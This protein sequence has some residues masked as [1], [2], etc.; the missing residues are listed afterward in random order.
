GGTTQ[1]SSIWQS[2]SPVV[3]QVYTVSY[4]YLPGANSSPQIVRAGGS[5]FLSQ[6]DGVI[7][8]IFVDGT[9]VYQQ[10]VFGKTVNYAFTVS[11][12]L[13]SKID[14]VLDAGNN[15][16]DYGDVASFTARVDTARP[17][18]TTVA[19]SAADWSTDGIQ[20]SKNWFYGYYNK[21][22]D[23]D[24][25]FQASNFVAFPRSIGPQS[26]ANFWDQEEWRWFNGDPPLDRLGQYWMTP[27]GT[28]SGAEHWV[29]RRWVSE[30]TG[31]LTILWQALKEFPDQNNSGGGGATLRLFHNGVQRD[32]QTIA[33][34]DVHGGTRALNIPNVQ[35]GDTIDIALDPTNVDGRE[36]DDTD[37]TFV[38]VTIGGY[39]SLTSQIASS[40]DASM[41]DINA[42]A[43]IRIPF[44]TANPS[45]FNSL[46]LRMKYDDG[47]IAYLNGVEVARAN[48]PIVATWNSSATAERSDAENN[49]WQEFN[50]GTELGLL[51]GGTNILSFQGLNVSPSDPDFLILPELTASTES[52]DLAATRYFKTP[53]PGTANGI[54]ET[55]LGPLILSAVHFP[56]IPKDNDNL[57][58][59]AQVA[60][61]LRA[62]GSVRLIYRVMYGNEVNAPMFDD[63][64]HGDGAAGDG[65][66]GATIPASASSPGQMVR[67]YIFATDSAGS[68]SRFPAYD[69]PQNSPQ[70]QGTV[71][72][73]PNLTN[74]L[75]VMQWFVQNPTLAS[76][77]AGTRCSI[78][79]DGEFFDNIGV[80]GHGQ[81]SW[82]LPTYL[83]P[84][85]SMDFNL[86]SGFKLRPKSGMD[87]VKAF[88]LLSPYGDKAYMRLTLA[89]ETFRDA[90]VPTHF[91]FPIRVQ[92][93][94]AFHSVMWLVEQANDDF[95]KRNNQDDN[96]AMYKIYFP[97]TDPYTG[98]KKVN[99]VNEP[100]DD[101]AGLINGLNKTGTD[102]RQYLFD[103]VDVAE[104]VNFFATI[105]LVQ[106]EDCCYYKNY[107]L[108]RD[109]LGNGQ[110]Q[111][112]PW[113]LDLTF[114]RTFTA[115][116]S[117]FN[118]QSGGYFDTNIF[119]LDAYFDEQRASEGF[120]G[121]GQPIFEA[122]WAFPDTREM[123][124]RRWTSVQEQFLRKTNT[125]PLAFYY[126][127]RIDQLTAQ[128][129]PDAALD[130]AKWG[131][132]PY[133][134]PVV[135]SQP[136]AAAVIKT[137][138]LAPRRNWIFNTLA[139]ANGGP[140]LGTQPANAT[141][142]FGQIEWSPSSG[143]QAQE[144]IQ[145]RNTNTYP[146]D[147]SGWKLSGGIDFTFKGGTVLPTNSVL[148]VSPDVN[149]FRART[150][151]PRG[152]QGLFVQG[153]YKGQLSARG[154][155]LQLSDNTGRI[156]QSTNFTGAPSLA[157]QSLRIT[158]I[159]YHPAGFPPGLA[160]NADEFEFIELKNVGSVAIP[161][162]GVRFVNG[163]DFDLTAASL[164]FLPAGQTMLLVKNA[165]AF[166]SR[167]GAGPNVVGEYSGSLDN[168]G[169]T[170]TL[171]DAAGEKILDFAYNNNWYPITD[172]LGFSLQIVNDHAAWDTW[173]QKSSWQPSGTLNGTP[174]LPNTVLPAQPP[175]IVNE[176]ISRTTPPSVD[177]I[178][179]FNPTGF[180][181]DLGGWFITDSFNTPKKFRI[182][183]GIVI[184][185]YDFLSFDE[186]W[187][188]HPTNAP[189]SFSFSASGD[190]AY[191]FSADADGNL[192]GYYHGFSFGPADAGVSFGRYANSVSNEQF[193]AQS[194]TSIWESNAGPLVGPVAITRIM[195]HPPDF[196]DGSDNSEDEFVELQNISGTNVAL[197]DPAAP[198]NTWRISGGSSFQFPTN[199][200]LAPGAFLVVAGFNPADAT[201]LAAFR[202]RLGIPV[203][204]PV[205]GPLSGK[206]ANSA[207][208][209]K[210]SKPGVPVS[211][212]EPPYILVDAINYD[213]TIPWPSEADGGGA[214]LQRRSAA[215]YGN[216][217][218]SWVA[219]VPA[220]GTVPVSA[221]PPAIV[222][223]TGSQVGFAT[224]SATFSVNATG[225]A[226][227]NYQWRHNGSAIAGATNST[228]VLNNLQLSQAGSYSA[229]VFNSAGAAST[230]NAQLTVQ[231][232][233]FFTQQP[234]SQNVTAGTNVTFTVAAVGNG[235]LTYQ[236]RF[237]GINI[238]QAT[239]PTLL[240]TNVSPSQ[241]GTYLA[242][243]T[244]GLVSFSSAPATLQVVADPIIVQQPV[245]VSV[246][247]GGTATL[248]VMITNNATLPAG[249]RWRRG[250]TTL[251]SN[252][253]SSY[254]NFLT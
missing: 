232:G 220:A 14:F 4:W 126:E 189:T 104:A 128:L 215:I 23:P 178:E 227:L 151:G 59:T 94:N 153:N 131:T 240:L 251:A 2:F 38:K 74:P 235:P 117:P 33:G 99:R 125:H 55:N 198:F 212:Q 93:N 197:F 121:G 160:T 3:G 120:I 89:F 9:E 158:E 237:N 233:A 8:R 57:L 62:V 155:L 105:E 119:Y 70:Y 176:V 145:L 236:W 138:Y 185:S 123:F 26:A 56:N 72:L 60:P 134:T 190:D 10:P 231:L 6:V 112:F 206:L 61:S 129:A 187:F 68:S 52:F 219:A 163:I 180:D 142:V 192:T 115:W 184:Y 209:V 100:N 226:P 79:W 41:R 54:G 177:A 71:V 208:S 150:S 140:Y 124:F 96:G 222:S 75:P 254:V 40:L 103:N 244:D 221:T 204:V 91:T 18:F 36:D 101:L 170:L 32:A 67:Y 228:L 191:L 25:V 39:P 173:G 65:V 88:D 85:K 182:P 95:L 169:E 64:Q 245:G 161:L 108:Y 243:I 133:A 116:P 87:R 164:D 193:V 199:L 217:P 27:T 90:G 162:D 113:D 44:V 43:Y 111:I 132:W 159:M 144:Y 50:L 21:S 20:G 146:V 195:Y 156:V 97:L 53:T 203:N 46:I 80:N 224:Q 118:G 172:G 188:N 149:A 238:P 213:S 216:D 122:L 247:F 106:N 135:Q 35:A 252:W 114:G 186:H 165:A 15:N 45:A 201:K 83:W 98:A 30:Y 194:S 181:V 205:L 136:A 5:W 11:S 143:N 102:L 230:T 13:G 253:V 174:G 141:V 19:D 31:D 242:V 239:S 73:N 17:G 84:N 249:Y 241:A 157:L 183:D 214:L 69:S 48:A 7:G 77:L 234:Q 51:R 66:W 49:T 37:R 207:E 86:N 22:A 210:L 63:G 12:H 229:V 127:N 92:Q 154:E 137:N 34:G 196:A 248:S 167:Y 1:S 78:F 179:L 200:T 58:V 171:V 168:A 166:T 130:L 110:W 246:P 42:S 152:G 211:G 81:T 16:Y 218:A 148:Y 76:D 175:I 24:K 202:T 28:N 29:I 107:Y 250:A 82:Q 47:F 139:Y 223:S 225:S 147:I 109:T